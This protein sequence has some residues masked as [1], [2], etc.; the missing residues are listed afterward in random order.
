[1][2][3]QLETRGGTLNDLSEVLLP[4]S[5]FILLAWDNDDVDEHDQKFRHYDIAANKMYSN[6][7]SAD[8]KNALE[9]LQRS[10]VC[11]HRCF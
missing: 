4:C 5:G 7:L 6:I 1:M 10:V 2:V 8:S 11:D 3:R 9:E